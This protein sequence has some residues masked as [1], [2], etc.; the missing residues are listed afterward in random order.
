[1]ALQLAVCL[2]LTLHQAVN[3]RGKYTVGHSLPSDSTVQLLAPAQQPPV[4]L[5]SFLLY[6]PG[7][8]GHTEPVPLLGTDPPMGRG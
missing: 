4:P 5:D 2:H 1:M 3:I 8:L 7:V 6:V